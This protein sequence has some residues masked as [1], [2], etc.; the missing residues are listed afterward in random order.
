MDHE[1]LGDMEPPF[2]PSRPEDFIAQSEMAFLRW[3]E[4]LEP[5]GTREGIELDLTTARMIWQ[6]AYE[7]QSVAIELVF[8][9]ANLHSGAAAT[10]AELYLGYVVD[11]FHGGS[12]AFPTKV[13]IDWL[14]HHEDDCFTYVDESEQV[15]IRIKS[16]G[17]DRLP[18][19]PGQRVPRVRPSSPET[20]RASALQSFLQWWEELEPPGSHEGRSLDLDEARVVWLAACVQMWEELECIHESAQAHSDVTS[21]TANHELAFL[22]DNQHH[23]K[24]T[25]DLNDL[26]DWS[27]QHEQNIRR[28]RNE[29]TVAIRIERTV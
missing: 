1:Q 9:S 6:T 22:V 12:V 11:R 28:S 18:M 26:M 27:Q 13:F 10:V 14:S 8:E 4:E 15:Q 3:W 29:D 21:E 24:L 20:V 7:H 17:D 16:R 5:P 25:F 23:G 19:E 2:E